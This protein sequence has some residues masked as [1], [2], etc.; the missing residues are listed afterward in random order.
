MNAAY[1][2]SVG[3]STG[4]SVSVG[5]S[6]VRAI[7]ERTSLTWQGEEVEFLPGAGALV[8]VASGLHAPIAARGAMNS[9]TQAAPFATA[10]SVSPENKEACA[11]GASAIASRVVAAVHGS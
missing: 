3:V 5:V 7:Q 4:V 10:S 6:D 1:A 11:D 2:D 8:G 9:T